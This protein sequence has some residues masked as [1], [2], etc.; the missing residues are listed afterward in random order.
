[1]FC[2]HAW[3]VLSETT[4][5]SQLEHLRDLGAEVEKGNMLMLERKYIQTFTCKK[6]GAFKRFV[7]EL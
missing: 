2:K 4:T 1:M 5:K 3:E 6:C 7:E